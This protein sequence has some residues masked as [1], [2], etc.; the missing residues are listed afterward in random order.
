MGIG[1]CISPFL[2]HCQATFRG[3]YSNSAENFKQP[4]N[5]EDSSNFDE[6]L[7]ESIAVTQTFIWKSFPRHSASKTN[8]ETG[9][10]ETFRL[11]QKS[12]NFE[13][14]SRFFGCLK[15]F[16][17]LGSLARWIANEMNCKW[18]VCKQVAEE[19][20]SSSRNRFLEAQLVR[21]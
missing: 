19:S 9:R 21:W 20:T 10:A 11:V 2:T 15:I 17:G 6:N 12:S 14:S 16:I 5:R 1:Y 4:K 18:V 13:L 8:Q 3:I 7:S